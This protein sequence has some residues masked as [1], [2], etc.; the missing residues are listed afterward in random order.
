MFWACLRGGKGD[1]VGGL[2]ASIT[3][4]AGSGWIWSVVVK[5]E[6]RPPILTAAQQQQTGLPKSA[7]PSNTFLAIYVSR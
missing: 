3:V 7:V 1:E 5:K 4:D 2:I 6:Q